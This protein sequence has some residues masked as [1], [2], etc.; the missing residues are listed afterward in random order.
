ML[1]AQPQPT[2]RV[3]MVTPRYYPAMGG[4]ETHVAQVAGHLV[5]AQVD[6][7]VLATDTTGA[8]SP[9]ECIDGVRVLRAPAWPRQRDYYFAPAIARTILQGG[10]DVVH[11]QSYH[12]LV[13]PLAMLAALRAR[14]PYV[15]T[16]HGGGHSSA[17]RNA[18]RRPQLALLRPLLARAARLV[19]VA[20]FEIGLYSRWLRVAAERFVLI[21]N[22]CDLPA[23]P[24]PPPASSSAPLILAVGRLERYKGHQRAIAA[25]PALLAQQPDARLRILGRGPYEAELRALAQRLGV[26]ERVEITSVAPGDRQGMANALAQAAVVALLSDF[27][28]H[29]IAAI[30]AIAAGRPVLVADTSGLAELA[31]RGLARAIAPSSSPAQVAQALLA[32]IRQ[33]LRPAAQALPT[34]ADCAQNLLSLYQHVVRAMP[35]AS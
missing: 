25:M 34:W 28:T 24:A 11:L 21:P 30:E 6:V 3:L 10:W 33:P 4:V 19:A 13:A 9:D 22:G 2:P 8:L 5:R 7:A 12:T 20:Q 27:E 14:I 15:V 17:L 32:Q 31:E 26:A 16:F 29:P 1:A 23:A 18:A 35:C